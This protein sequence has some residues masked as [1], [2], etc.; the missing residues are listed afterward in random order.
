M[1]KYWSL[2]L[3]VCVQ[4]TCCKFWPDDLQKSVEYSFVKVNLVDAV[5]APYADVITLEA[6]E[7]KQVMCPSLS[8][9]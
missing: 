4:S 6:F 7:K 8:D 9:M 5:P 3:S 1:V 2:C